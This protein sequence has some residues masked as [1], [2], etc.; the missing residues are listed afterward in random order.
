VPP[1][2]DRALGAAISGWL[3]DPALREDLR[4]LAR[5][6]RAMLAGWEQ[7]AATISAALHRLAAA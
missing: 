4:S 5:S 7:P 2:D 3:A 1:E 6:R